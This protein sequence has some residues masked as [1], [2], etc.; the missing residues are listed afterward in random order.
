[1]RPDGNLEL[2]LTHQSNDSIPTPIYITVRSLGSRS[3]EIAKTNFNLV[4]NSDH[5][6]KLKVSEDH[7]Y[8]IYEDHLFWKLSNDKL[9]NLV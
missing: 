6:L 8:S 5:S 1:V 7:L 9:I 4:G 2:H 3:L